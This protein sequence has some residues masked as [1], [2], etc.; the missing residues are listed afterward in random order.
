MKK[1]TQP[2]SFVLTKKFIL[3][4]ALIFAIL[5]NGCEQPSEQQEKAEY[6]K[7]SVL[8]PTPEAQIQEVAV[9]PPDEPVYYPAS[10]P[11]A[12]SVNLKNDENITKT[13]WTVR[14]QFIDSLNKVVPVYDK[15]K[16]NNL[17]VTYFT[18]LAHDLHG[19]TFFANNADSLRGSI[20]DI[21][22]SR[23]DDGTDIVFLIDKTG[24]M[25][26]DLDKV[27]GSMN[28][29]MDY[30][31]NFHNVKL[32]IASY[33]DKNYQYDFWYNRMDLSSDVNQIRSYMDSYTTIGNPD[34][35]ES[36][37]DAIVKTVR[38]MNWTEGNKRLM[39]VIG[40][41]PSQ[42]PPLS[43]YSEQQVIAACDSM[44]VKFNLYPIILSMTAQQQI[45]VPFRNNFVKTY[46]NPVNQVLNAELDAE[47]NYYFELND[48]SGKR[49]F[50]KTA[51]A[52]NSAM[53]LS[54]VNNGTYL[55]QIYNEKADKYYSSK[56]I[57][58]H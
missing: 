30:L 37:N 15:S 56:I 22:S 27:K 10:H 33:G 46:P 26:D 23:L 48:M 11:I 43:S 29:I 35:P 13:A 16:Y 20:M 17:S 7:Q 34:V 52:K 55:L 12:K 36:V 50:L 51:N 28:I 1:F 39:L 44:K 6:I 19:R 18:S 54:S 4:T 47:E 40:D 21:L 45:D 41:A 31:S 24:S 5:L 49:V 42:Q 25:D 14:E 32:A 8:E 58:Q 57:V 3:P 2:D 53:D 38:E 9:T